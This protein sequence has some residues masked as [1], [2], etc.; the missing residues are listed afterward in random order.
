MQSLQELQQELERYKLEHQKLSQRV[1]ELSDFIEN[2]SVPI[3]WV[4]ENGII[5]WANQAELDLLGY[6]ADEYIGHHIKDFHQDEFTINDILQRLSSDQIL[7]DFPA[8]LKS[9]DDSVKH[10]RI[11]SNVY[12]KN[13]EF[14]HTRCITTDITATIENELKQA[15]MLTELEESEARLRMALSI[16]NLGT[17]DYNVTNGILKWSEGCKEIYG[18]NPDAEVDYEAFSKHIYPDDREFV[19]AE[20]KK[21]LDPGNG[22]YD[23]IYRITRF[24]NDAVVWIKSYGKVYFDETGKAVRFIGS[25]LDIT[26]AKLANE[27]ILRNEKLFKAI[28]QNI[29]NSLILIIDKDHRFLTVE[30]D[31][32]EKLGYKPI[33]YKGTHPSDVLNADRYEAAKPLFERV[34][35][36]KTFSVEYKAATGE[37]LKIHLIPLKDDRDKVYA[38]LLIAT[39]ITD[40]KKAEEKGAKLAAIVESSDDAIISKTLEGIITSWNDAAKRLFGYTAD[41]IIGKPIQT[42]FPEDRLDEETEIL[43]RL[44]R[45]ERVEHFETQRKTKDGKIIDLSLTISPIRDSKNNIIGLSKIARDITSKKQEDMRKNDFIAIVSHELKTPLT[46]VK[47]YVQLLL[48]KAKKENDQFITNALSRTEIQV[49]KMASMINDFLS[50]A[51]LEEGKVYLRMEDFE[52]H[53]LMVELVNDAQFLASGHTIKLQDCDEI[54]VH[55]DRDKIGQ[56]LINLLSNAIKYSP[57]GTTIILGCKKVAGKVNIYVTDEGIGISETDQ[58]RLFERFYRVDNQLKTVSGFGI[59]LYLV[60]EILKFHDSKIIVE[61]VEGKGSTFSFEL[62][63]VKIK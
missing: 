41:E 2:A 21:A 23:I 59:G 26:S 10:V 47:S 45:G 16:S 56:V 39:D 61:S 8:I 55:G 18:L 19:E 51:R 36:G 44:H 5:I 63:E 43:S 34:L 29:P 62:E 40:S 57:K 3:H 60:S 52:L 24:D 33:D 17:W 9:K 54:I 48:A 37:D 32:M 4:D 7:K 38:G 11:N 27:Q 25:V 15:E 50:L 30:G 1:E 42:L 49:N 28:V 58:K 35:S 20:I 53:V 13:G 22:S 14:I 6:S 12:R 46:S 31:L